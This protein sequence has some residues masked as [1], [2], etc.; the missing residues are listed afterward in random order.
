M[1]WWITI[2]GFLLGC[3]V[4]YAMVQ[5]GSDSDQDQDQDKDS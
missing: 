1:I 2:G 5:G 3:L 4:A